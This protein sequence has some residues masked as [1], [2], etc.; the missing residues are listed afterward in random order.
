MTRPRSRSSRSW[1]AS[2]RWLI[3]A[4]LSAI[5]IG[6]VASKRIP[7]ARFFG[8]RA[9]VGD[10]VEVR[11][12]GALLGAAPG[13]PPETVGIV[14]RVATSD[15]ETL[16]GKVS[17]YVSR[18]GPTTIAVPEV[19]PVTVRRSEVLRIRRDGQEVG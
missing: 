10:E 17:A 8:D 11:P 1:L 6:L 16:S 14:V 4:G 2:A 18:V 3:P 12:T 19:F 7:A 5:V 13:L 9:R 15:A